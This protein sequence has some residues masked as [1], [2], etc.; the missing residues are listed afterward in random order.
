MALTVML[1]RESA[2]GASLI[3]LSEQS[4]RSNEQGV[5]GTAGR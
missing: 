3:S 1:V 4:A 2:A 5:D